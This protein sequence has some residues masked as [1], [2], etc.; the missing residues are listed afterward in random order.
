MASIAPYGSSQ[1]ILKEFKIVG[2]LKRTGTQDDGTVF[3]PIKAAQTLFNRPQ[4]L[5]ILGIKLKQF[6][7]A[8]MQEFESR[9]I[10]LPEVQVVSL[11]QVKST[12][13]MLIGI[14]V[15]FLVIQLFHSMLLNM[16][17]E[18]LSTS[19]IF[20]RKGLGIISQVTRWI[21]PFAGFMSSKKFMGIGT[22]QPYGMGVLYSIVYSFIFLFYR[23]R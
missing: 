16:D 3:L 6:S 22:I 5:T 1:T 10:K 13:A 14:L 9:W 20:L 2:V 23:R 17:E 8:Q 12:L 4:Q 21:S 19:V 11:E 7:A 18:N 15:A